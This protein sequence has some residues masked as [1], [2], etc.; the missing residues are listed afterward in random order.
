MI[1]DDLPMI[2]LSFHPDFP[3]KPFKEKLLPPDRWS[4][5]ELTG[6]PTVGSSSIHPVGGMEVS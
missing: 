3:S 4:T 6:V 2:Y 5:L 1:E